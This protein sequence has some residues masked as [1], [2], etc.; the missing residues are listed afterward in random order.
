MGG[1][2]FPWPPSPLEELSGGV[3][4]NGSDVNEATTIIILCDRCDAATQESIKGTFLPV[5]EDIAAKGKASG[6]P[7]FICFIATKPSGPVPQVKKLTN[8][9]DNKDTPT[10]M[11]LDIPDNGGYY[12]SPAEEVTAETLASFLDMYRAKALNRLQ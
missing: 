10:L 2:A 5:A 12:V 4:C 9:P 1:A 6:E 11:I 3:E 7:E 8:Q